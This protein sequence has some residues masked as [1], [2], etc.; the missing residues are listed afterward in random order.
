MIITKN[1]NKYRENQKMS[2]RGL[3][4]VISDYHLGLNCTSKRADSAADLTKNI[5]KNPW[6]SAPTT[7]L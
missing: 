5:E 2:Y 4:S 3:K 7:Y 1:K 6:I